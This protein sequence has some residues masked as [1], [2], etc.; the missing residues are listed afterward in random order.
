MESL[1]PP[2]RRKAGLDIEEM[3]LKIDNDKI[4][5]LSKKLKKGLPDD[6]YNEII[7]DI[8]KIDKKRKERIGKIKKVKENIFKKEKI[9]E[10]NVDEIMEL[11]YPPEQRS[12][13]LD[14][15]D[16]FNEVD[17]SKK[18]RIKKVNIDEIMD[19]LLSSSNEEG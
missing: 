14:A 10:A 15:E 7:D 9:E 12:A 13:N 6:E 1:Y 2:E 4:S 17:K 5:N 19:L 3:L 8:N 16:K 11:F 18:G